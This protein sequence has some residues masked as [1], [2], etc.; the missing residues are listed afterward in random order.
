[1]MPA[2]TLAWPATTRTV[3]TIGF[4]SGWLGLVVARE[5]LGK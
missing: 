4:M 3:I 2:L 1:V 5:I